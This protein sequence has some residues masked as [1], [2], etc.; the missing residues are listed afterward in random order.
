LLAELPLPVFIT[1]NADP[2]LEE[3]LRAAGKTP[4]SM[5]CPWNEYVEQAETVFDRDPDYQPE[6]GHPLVFHLFGRWD[7]PLSVVLTEDNYFKFLIGVTQKRKLIPARV[8]EMLSDSGLLFLGF[9]TEEW[10]FRVLYHS[11]L[12]QGSDRH[13]LYTNIA[14][15][16]EPEDER[17]LEPAGAKRYLEQYFGGADISIYWGGPGEFLGE[18]L[19][20]WREAQA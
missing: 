4:E 9:Q 10:N 16:I 7:E 1:T 13:N 12:A 6:P 2:L 17:I 18:L 5:L 8:R 11:I 19:R 3:A 20:Q 15:Q 14:A